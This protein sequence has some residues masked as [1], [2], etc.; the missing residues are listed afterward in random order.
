M[1]LKRLIFLAAAAYIL[2]V[3]GG[4]LIYR[5]LIAYPEL[6]QLTLESHK[7]DIRAIKSTYEG[8]LNHLKLFNSDWAKWDET[9][10]FLNGQD[11]GYIERNINSDSFINSNV[12]IVS[13]YDSQK[14]HILTGKTTGAGLELLTDLS[15]LTNDIHLDTVLNRDEVCALIRIGKRIGYFCSNSVQ[16]SEETNPSN[17]TL[18]F[19]RMIDNSIIQ[20]L[21]NLTDSQIS[22][23]SYDN[24]QHSIV[25]PPSLDNLPLTDG[26]YHFPLLNGKNIPIGVLNI[27]YQKE[28]LPVLIDKNTIISILAMLMLPILITIF[29]YYFFLKPMTTIFSNIGT[30]NKTGKLQNISIHTHIAEIDAFTANFNLF[31]QQIKQYQQKLESE[32][33]TDGLTNLFNRRYFDHQYDEMWR[34]VSRTGNS[35]SI[36]MMD[37]DFFKKYNDHYGHQKGDDALKAVASK[38]KTVS[39]RAN[40]TLARY[41]GEEFVLITESLSKKELEDMLANIINSIETLN[42][43]HKPSPISDLLTISCGA[44]YIENPGSWMKDKKEQALKIADDSLYE[45]KENG[46]NQFIIH[47]L[48]NQS[49]NSKY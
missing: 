1:T 48:S 28:Q 32:S 40:E 17:G 37:I 8:E 16:D 43:E 47:P 14:R 45:A 29:V 25:I 42:L 11:P 9:Y 3:G 39:R 4:L 33:N 46:R 12:D 13:I 15:E 6:E 38:L 49:T 20:R 23:R 35:I 26:R 27:H 5:I 31:I 24:E 36:V 19:I 41:G 44:C 34:A 7:G 2:V 21:Q 22:L 18:I 10:A 30:M